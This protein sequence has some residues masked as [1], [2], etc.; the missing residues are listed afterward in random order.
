[1]H[2]INRRRC[3]DD[4]RIRKYINYE[5]EPSED[6]VKVDIAC[7]V[8]F[9]WFRGFGFGFERGWV[10]V[11]VGRIWIVFGFEGRDDDCGNEMHALEIDLGRSGRSSKT[12]KAR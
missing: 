9:G 7:E 6:E 4:E 1:M 12:Y 3:T 10:C 11:S 8:R 2:F 5:R